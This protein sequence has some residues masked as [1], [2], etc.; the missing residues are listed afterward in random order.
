MVT[1]LAGLAL[2]YWKRIRKS[3]ETCFVLFAVEAPFVFA[4]L[5]VPEEPLLPSTFFRPLHPPML[6]PLPRLHRRCRR[7]RAPT[8]SEATRQR[9]FRR[10]HPS[11]FDPC[12]RPSRSL[13]L[14][15][16]EGGGIDPRRL[17]PEEI[18]PMNQIF[19]LDIRPLVTKCHVWRQIGWKDKQRVGDEKIRFNKEILTRLLSQRTKN[20]QRS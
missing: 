18:L 8:S 16:E 11:P 15:G 1:R 14:P 6:S 3:L 10:I 19:F 4:V 13:T 5:I 20:P 7:R 17:L 2:V 9:L 12:C